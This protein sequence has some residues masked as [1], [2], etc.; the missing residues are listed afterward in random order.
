MAWITRLRLQ[1]TLAVLAALLAPTLAAAQAFPSR[2]IRLIVPFPPGG[3]TDA[4]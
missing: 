4:Y 2:P 3:A 1:A